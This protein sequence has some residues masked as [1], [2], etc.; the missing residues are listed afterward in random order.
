[1][2]TNLLNER[3][4]TSVGESVKKVTDGKS[5]FNYSEKYIKTLTLAELKSKAKE[6]N[7]QVEIDSTKKEIIESILNKK[8]NV[9]EDTSKIDDNALD[10]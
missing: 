2:T 5:V 6:L 4:K 9:K 3:E 10:A 1:M 8:T 7:I